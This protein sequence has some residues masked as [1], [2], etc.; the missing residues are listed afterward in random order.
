MPDLNEHGQQV[1]D[2]LEGWPPPPQP[3]WVPLSGRTTDVEPLDWARHGGALFE[4]FAEAGDDLWTYMTFGPF[5]GP[6][7]LRETMEWMASQQDWLPYAITVEGE[8]LGFASYLRINPP[9]GVIEIGAITL[10][11]PLQ[12]TTPAT[13]ALYLMIQNVFRLGYRRC[14]WKCDSLNQASRR[15]GERLGF[16]YEGTFRKAM[17]YKGRNR[18]TAWFAI[19]D[20]DWPALD[21]AYSVWLSPDNFDGRGRQRRRLSDLIAASRT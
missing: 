1:G 4:R 2:S 17:H 15:A 13:E 19:T 11:P 5:P 9:M 12:R 14:E 18:D 10:S 7:D 16:R 3:P 6:D 8:P 21:Q 20:D